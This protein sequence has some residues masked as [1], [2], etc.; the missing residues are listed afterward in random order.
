[1]LPPSVEDAFQLVQIVL[2]HMSVLFFG[3]A[4][5]LNLQYGGIIE[6]SLKY[7]N[8]ADGPCFAGHAFS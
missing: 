2:C 4:E 6:S 8:P 7:G 3:E 5:S 1:M